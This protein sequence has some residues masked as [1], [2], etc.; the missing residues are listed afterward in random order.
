MALAPRDLD[1]LASFDPGHHALEILCS[2][3]V[4]IET[5]CL[6][7]IVYDKQKSVKM[8]RAVAALHQCRRPRRIRIGDVA[9][10]VRRA[11]FPHANSP[12]TNVSHSTC[13]SRSRSVR[14]ESVA[15]HLGSANATSSTASPARTATMMNCLPFFM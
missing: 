11:T 10:P 5:F 3:R 9:T 8:P 2:S 7:D 1:H 12:T 13:P 14:R 15:R 6:Y 4:E